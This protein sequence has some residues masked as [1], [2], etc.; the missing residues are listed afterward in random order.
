VQRFEIF[1]ESSNFFSLRDDTD[2]FVEQESKKH[3]RYLDFV[4]SCDFLED[5]VVDDIIETSKRR[6][7][8]DVDTNFLAETNELRLLKEDMEFDLI[9]DRLDL[10]V[11]EQIN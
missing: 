11:R 8:G 6:V 2:S 9:A 10:C 5:F 1:F 4:L 3:L 7:R